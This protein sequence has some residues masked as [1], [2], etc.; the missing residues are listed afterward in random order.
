[1]PKYQTELFGQVIYAKEMSYD[2]LLALEDEIKDF[3]TVSLEKEGGQYLGFESEGDRTFFQ[4][5]F[6]TCDE[7][8]MDRLAKKFAK[9]MHNHLESKLMFVERMLNKHVFYGINHKKAQKQLIKLPEAGPIDKA[10][11]EEGA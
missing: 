6:Q 3:I 2:A 5:A 8:C 10:L 7:E 1:M 4:C 9:R 11:M